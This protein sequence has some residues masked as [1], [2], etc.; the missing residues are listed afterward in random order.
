MAK[1]T[2]ISVRKEDRI[3]DLRCQG[4]D[5]DT[6]AKI[7][8]TSSSLTRVIR[9]VGK[10]PETGLHNRKRW[11]LDDHQVDSIRLRR[12]QGRSVS[13]LAKEQGLSV[14]SIYRL[15]SGRTYSESEGGEGYNFSF[16][17]RLVQGS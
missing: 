4:Y 16:A 9:R 1:R 7:V 10:R 8:N 3:W 11:F 2:R 13:A 15:C 5:Y 17:N 6:I 14:S 12:S